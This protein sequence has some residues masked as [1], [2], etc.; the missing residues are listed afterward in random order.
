[1]VLLYVGTEAPRPALVADILALAG[2]GCAIGHCPDWTAARDVYQLYHDVGTSVDAFLAAP[3]AFPVSR[4]MENIRKLAPRSDV[5]ALRKP[6]RD[7]V[8]DDE[9]TSR[10]DKAV[11]AGRTAREE[12]VRALNA[13]QIER[14]LIEREAEKMSRRITT[15]RNDLN[16]NL[17]IRSVLH[18][19]IN[20][21][22]VQLA[23]DKE[24]NTLV[25]EMK[26]LSGRLCSS[27]PPP[28]VDD[29]RRLH[30]DLFPRLADLRGRTDDNIHK[31]MMGY[32][33]AV[34]RSLMGKGGFY[35]ERPTSLRRAVERIESA[36]TGELAPLELDPDATGD[37]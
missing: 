26:T 9:V 32:V 5:I 14:L 20:I 12:L 19:L 22:Q 27:A 4:D 11:R 35:S 17:F 7:I 24:E 34:Q 23:L 21:L 8:L 36:R 2:P 3:G 25:E 29:C 37:G 13:A 33:K 10:I 1:M 15:L 31:T 18:T 16:N 6:G 28:S 30:R